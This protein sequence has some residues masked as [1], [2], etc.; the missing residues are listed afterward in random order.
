MLIENST[1]VG[2]LVLDCFAGSAQ[3]L[4]TAKKLQRR[5]IGFEKDEANFLRAQEYMRKELQ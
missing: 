3:T 4:V 1:N 5:A 2:E